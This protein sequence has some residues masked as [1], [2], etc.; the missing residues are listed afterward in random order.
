MVLND[1]SVSRR[2]AQLLPCR[3]AVRGAR[4][5]SAGGSFIKAIA[6]TSTR[7]IVGDRLQV[8]PFF[9][10]SMPRTRSRFEQSGARSRLGLFMQVT[11][12]TCSSGSLAAGGPTDLDNISLHV[13]ASRFSVIGPSGAA[14]VAAHT[15][16][17]LRKPERGIVWSTAWMFT[18]G[19]A[20]RIRIRPPDDIVHLERRFGSAPFAARCVSRRQSAA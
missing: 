14:I 12:R 6:S 15:L 8:G 18:P 3:T 9:F 13:P 20:R 17:G 16:A 11:E 4:L 2:H 5:Q 10:S 19:A 1:P 7:F